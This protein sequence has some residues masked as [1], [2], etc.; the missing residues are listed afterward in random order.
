MVSPIVL[1]P[2][3]SKHG[4]NHVLGAVSGP[5]GTLVFIQDALKKA[6]PT[7][8]EA[9]QIDAEIDIE[10]KEAVGAKIPA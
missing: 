5:K 6:W 4:V 3:S 2:T 10:L 9:V 1:E 7:I 8:P